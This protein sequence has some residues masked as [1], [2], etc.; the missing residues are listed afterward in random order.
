MSAPPNE[1]GGPGVRDIAAKAAGDV[2]FLTDRRF[3]GGLWA[4]LVRSPHPRAEVQRI[5]TTAV[6]AQ[7]GVEAVFT[8]AD[9][10][11]TA[12]NPAL[13]PG[14]AVSRAT[15]D[16]QLLTR[17]PRHVGDE[18]AV[19]VA[20]TRAQAY[21]AAREAPVVWAVGEPVLTLEAALATRRVG[22]L[23]HGSE[24]AARAMAVADVTVEDRFTFAAAQHTC[25]EGAAC[26]A[27]P[28]LGDTA[29][30]IWTNTQC[31][32]QVRRQVASILAIDPAA[33]RVR[34][35]D[36]GGGFGAKQDLYAEPLAAWLALRLGRPVRLASTRAEELS[37]GRVRSGGR[38][39]LRLG[40][41]RTG[42]MVASEMAA[43]LDCGAYV[44]HTP[45]V[46]S[47]LPG[48]LA[49]VYP[50]AAHGFTGSLVTTDTI[51]SGAYRGYGVAEANF[52]VE[53]LMDVAAARLGLS[54]AEIRLRNLVDDKEGRGIAACL[55][56][57]AGRSAAPTGD[58]AVRR[59][60]GLAV[61]AKHSITG[62]DSDTTVAAVTL[63]P[64]PILLL[65]TGTCDSGTGSS[66][67]LARIVADEFGAPLASVR[68]SEGDTAQISDL[69]STA[70][71]SVYVGGAAARRAARSAR[72]A[73]V[74]A[75]GGERSD[76]TLRW[77]LLVDAG[78]RPAVH[79]GDLAA[80][81]DAGTLGA[82][83]A[84][85]PDGRGASY[86][87]LGVEV[88]VDVGT[89]AVRVE[90]AD[91]VVD[92]GS[93][94]DARGAHGQVAGGVV[95]GIGLACF[96]EWTSGPDGR[97]P[98]SILEH[99]AV[100]AADAPEV[101]VEFLDPANGHSPSGLGELPIVPVAAA[102]AN[103]VAAATGVRCPRTPLRAPQVWQRLRQH[104][105]GPT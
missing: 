20:H 78:G 23:G 36:E 12:Y 103:A 13:T 1:P 73:I 81:R 21:R 100:R 89:G 101:R 26:V 2:Q 57:I 65:T 80:A 96:D 83:A 84:A 79:L 30:E 51:P 61:A 19:V 8:W 59:G 25:L 4:A 18:V 104:R 7:D 69:G 82:R 15:R 55:R 92:C 43:V 68:V 72:A 102:V 16:K 9:V 41:R 28:G 39:D 105:D 87:A 17:S 33:V 35:V 46:L 60:Y 49:A 76:L 42:V 66:R 88:A 77:P 48:H 22:R 52:A 70:Q 94:L 53:Q 74:R 29:V 99:G 40:F 11:A 67:A 47:C 86:C 71:R 44:S 56:R 38:I 27:L 50:R 45:Y 10:P 93:V 32:A 75:A 5:D 14:D 6:L 54:P 97:G 37:A 34:K 85:R 63:M 58:G 62:D 90:R 98:A 64:G 24:R 31:P 3:P 95:Q 91:A